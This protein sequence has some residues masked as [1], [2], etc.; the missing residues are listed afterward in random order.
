MTSVHVRLHPIREV[1]AGLIL[2]PLSDARA[3][4]QGYA[5]IMAS[6]P[7]EFGVLAGVLP[8]PDGSPVVFLAPLWS[9]ETV[10]GLPIIAEL[11]RLGTP[12]IAQV[13]RWRITTYSACSMRRS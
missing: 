10:D 9:G 1:L 7:E 2:F 12:I 3:V 13:A 11:Q 5:A 6:A 8:G 4:L